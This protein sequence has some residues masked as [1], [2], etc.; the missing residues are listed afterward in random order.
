MGCLKLLPC[1]A[2]RV[3]LSECLAIAPRQSPFPTAILVGDHW[4]WESVRKAEETVAR[5]RGILYEA[6]GS[7]WRIIGQAPTA[8]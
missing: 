7:G 1:R 6:V 4:N 5:T 3:P 2:S 8:S